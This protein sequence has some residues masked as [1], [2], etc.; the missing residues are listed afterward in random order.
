MGEIRAHCKRTRVFRPHIQGSIRYC[1]KHLWIKIIRQCVLLQE[2]H[3]AGQNVLYWPR[4]CQYF[5]PVGR[6][7]AQSSAPCANSESRGGVLDKTRPRPCSIFQ[8]YRRA[9]FS[10]IFERRALSGF[11][12]C[13]PCWNAGMI[14]RQHACSVSRRPVCCA[15]SF[16][17][18]SGWS[19]NT[20]ERV[21]NRFNSKQ[22]RGGGDSA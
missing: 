22:L 19:F 5:R 15:Q 13:Y 21:G 7:R 20:A 14:R 17:G 10:S 4:C 12:C 16:P 9:I 8:R 2:M 11:H 1:K 3:H 6:G 18:R